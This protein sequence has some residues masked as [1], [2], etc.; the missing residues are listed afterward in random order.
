MS[1][2]T[3]LYEHLA[4]KLGKETAETM[5]SFIDHKIKDGINDNLRVLATRQ[6]LVEGLAASKKDLVEGLAASKQE[7]VEGLAASKKDLVEGLAASKKDLVEGLSGIR[8]ELAEKFGQIDM[9]IASTKSD[10]IKWMFI[11]WTGQLV[12]TFLFIQFFLRK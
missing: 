10:I 5:T 7:L 3:Q 6:D 4:L 1:T 8:V 12:A 9:K 2:I 11:F